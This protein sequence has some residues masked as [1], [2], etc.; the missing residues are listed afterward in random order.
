MCVLIIA[1]VTG[2]AS[3]QVFPRV[4][5]WDPC[6]STSTLLIYYNSNPIYGYADDV[7]LVALVE[8]PK[9]RLDVSASLNEDLTRTYI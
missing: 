6:C 3:T 9:S 7:T 8:S 4:A 5:Y 2:T 1:T